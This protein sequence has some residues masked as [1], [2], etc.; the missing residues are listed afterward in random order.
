ML[1]T[2]EFLVSRPAVIN[3]VVI[4]LELGN[5]KGGVK[6]SFVITPAGRMLRVREPDGF[7][8]APGTPAIIDSGDA[9]VRLIL[10]I[11]P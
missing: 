8:H 5:E 6:N 2:A 3:V 4:H 10:H 1:L 7:Q 11:T 9:R